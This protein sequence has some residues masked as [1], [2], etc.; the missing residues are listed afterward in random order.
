M[1]DKEPGEEWENE[2]DGD[3]GDATA[4]DP[5]ALKKLRST[6]AMDSAPDPALDG[7]ADELA[8]GAP[9]VMEEDSASSL[10]EA[11]DP[12]EDEVADFDE[13]SVTRMDPS[14]MSDMAKAEGAL[15]KKPCPSCGVMVSPGYPKCPRCK[16]SFVKPGGAKYKA[17]GTALVGRT[18]PWTIVFIAAVVT[19]I[20]VYLSERDPIEDDG[21]RD[22][23][24]DTS[25]A[26]GSEPE[27][28]EESAPEEPAPEEPA[29][30]EEGE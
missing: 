3:G 9:T 22:Q 28:P 19:A 10:L 7:A 24:S 8:G 1:S 6:G 11:V 2:F 20:I 23:S 16:H 26:E 17:G 25:G 12:E 15:G 21:P 14:A 13:N 29:V 30:E 18:V 5:D 4:I 27:A